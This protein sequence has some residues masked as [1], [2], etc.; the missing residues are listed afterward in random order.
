M[1]PSSG[2]AAAHA[3]EEHGIALLHG[4]RARG[5][6]PTCLRVLGDPDRDRHA[7]F[8]HPVEDVAPDLCLSSLIGQSTGAKASADNGLI[9]IH[10]GFGQ[11]AAIIARDSL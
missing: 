3:A 10:S 5:R 1:R 6:F 4:S 7:E 11:A 9:P 2:P 8:G